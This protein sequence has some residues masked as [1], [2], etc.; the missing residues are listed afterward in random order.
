MGTEADQEVT[1][2]LIAVI[3]LLAGMVL[4]QRF[5][6]L[7]LLPA[8]GL[9]AIV[10]VGSGMAQGE[11]L[12]A[13]ALTAIAAIVSVQLGYL[14]GLSIRHLLATM[15][16]SRLRATSFANPLPTRRSAH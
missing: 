13:T 7:A 12:S 3:S 6:V 14:L 8:I 15:H 10:C 11:S 9:L 5:K 1:R 16:A 4:G 2:M